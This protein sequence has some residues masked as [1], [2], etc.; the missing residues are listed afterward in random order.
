MPEIISGLAVAVLAFVAVWMWRRKLRLQREADARD[1]ARMMAAL[2]W[3]PVNPAVPRLVAPRR[4]AS[5][6]TRAGERLSF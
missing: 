1:R 4:V 3:K 2:R 6:G 5:V